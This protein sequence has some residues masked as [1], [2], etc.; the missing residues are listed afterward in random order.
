MGLVIVGGPLNTARIPEL[1]PLTVDLPLTLDDL[2]PIWVA[3]ENKTKKVPLQAI[4]DLITLGPG[5]GSHA[6]VV[7]GGE[8]IYIVAQADDGNVTASI[9]SLAGLDFTLERGG[10]P[11]IALLPDD[12]NA[13][14]AEYEI[15]DAGGFK[16]LKAGDTLHGLERFKLSIFSL[17]AVPSSPGG[18]SSSSFINGKKVVTTSLTLDPAGDMNKLIQIRADTG[19]IILTLPPVEDIPVKSFIPIETNITNS[20]AAKIQTTGGQYIYFNNTGKTSVYMHPGEILWLF[21]DD[22]GFYVINDFYQNYRGLGVP[23]PAYQAE[24]NQLVCRGQLVSR[25]AFPRLWEYVQTLGL[26]I[27]TD[28]LW[29]TAQVYRQGNTY[30][31]SVPGSGIY[32]IIPNPYRGCFSSGDGAT[33]FRLPD[34]MNMT[35]RGVKSLSGTDNERYLNRPGIFQENMLQDHF[36]E[37][38]T[39]TDPASKYRRGPVHNVR[40]WGS[41]TTTN[42]GASTDDVEKGSAAA[43]AGMETRGDNVGYLWVIKF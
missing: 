18:S 28:S 13:G 34:L 24:L 31:T 17:M 19:S 29:S 42:F 16:L 4:N 5:A 26:S 8:M 38:G 30:S 3:S 39:E 23:S 40:A 20:K 15:L 27:V 41:T 32:S 25:D 6:P 21:R 35:L 14:V 37:S 11:L 1:S 33:T 22:D 36:H 9:T 43:N 7:F 2:I 12:S 10:F